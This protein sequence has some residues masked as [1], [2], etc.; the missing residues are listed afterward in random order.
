MK[1]VDIFYKIRSKLI[2]VYSRKYLLC[3]CIPT[4]QNMWVYKC[5]VNIYRQIWH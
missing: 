5:K 2:I 1:Y 4:Y 3:M